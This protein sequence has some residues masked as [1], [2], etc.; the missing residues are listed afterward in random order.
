VFRKQCAACHQLGGIGNA[1]GPDLASLGDKS[2]QALLIAILDPNRAVEA[3]YVGY[4]AITKSG[5]TFTG[6]LTSETGNSITLVGPDGKSEVIL[7]S[8]LEELTSSGKSAMPE[9]LEKEVKPE[10][11]A[12]LIAHVRSVGPQPKPK[13]FA[14]NKPELVRPAR[15]GSL[16]LRAAD[17]EVYGPTVLF[18]EKYGNL[19]YW[20]SEDDRA[21]WT[22]EV[23]RAGKYAVWL[24]WA[25]EE[26]SAGKGFLLQAGPN[27]LT[28]KVRSTGNWDTYR[29][30]KVG[31]IVLPAGRQRLTLRSQR[32]IFSPMIDLKSIKLV[33]LPAE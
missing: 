32:R 27:Q 18:E 26:N 9:G 1:V 22:V 16:L 30:A 11:M 17:C 7:R 4:T 3:R 33:P 20:T 2:P 19:G 5:K 8:D 23:T 6:V 21:I 24:D 29:Q 31:E 12:D 28:G 15:D 13:S 25:C 14:G 10:D